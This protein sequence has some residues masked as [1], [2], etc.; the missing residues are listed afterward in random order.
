MSEPRGTGLGATARWI[1]IAAFLL[2]A[3]TG[4]GRISGSDEVTMFELSRAMLHGHIE[5]PA[6]GAT[7]QGPDGRFYSKNIIKQ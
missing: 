7:V 4:G 1:A 3:W 5:V 2:Y 6:E